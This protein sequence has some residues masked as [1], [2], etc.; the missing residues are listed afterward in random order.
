MT[1]HQ[2]SLGVTAPLSYWKVATG[3]TLRLQVPDIFEQL[4]CR[5][6]SWFY[7]RLAFLHIVLIAAGEIPVPLPLKTALWTVY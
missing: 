2:E 6:F 1:S 5:K 7:F 3:L 4:L